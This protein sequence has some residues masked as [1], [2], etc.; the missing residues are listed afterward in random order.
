[1]AGFRS[2][3]G[4]SLS[5]VG[6]RGFVWSSTV[7]SSYSRY[8]YFYSSLAT[9]ASYTRAPGFSVRCLRD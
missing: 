3:S 1:V 9:M 5:S 7:S 4:G 8:L 6:S 2:F